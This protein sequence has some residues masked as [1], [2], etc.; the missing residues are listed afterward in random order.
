MAAGRIL[1]TGAREIRDVMSYVEGLSIPLRRRRALDFGCG[2]GRLTQALVR[3][4][5]EV[6][7]VDIAPS[8]IEWARKYNGCGDHCLYFVNASDDLATSRMITLISSIPTSHCSTLSPV[9]RKDTS[10]NFVASSH[11]REF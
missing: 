3:Y 8:M 5:D 10:R 9:I 7:G 6:C 2:V 11:G 1:E 4:F